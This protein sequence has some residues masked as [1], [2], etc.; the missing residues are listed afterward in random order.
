MLTID[1]LDTTKLS[2]RRRFSHL[3]YQFYKGVPQWVPPILIDV[4]TAMN[5]AKHPFYE[6]SDADFF[7]ANRDGQ[8]VGR[9]S[10]IE[11]KPYNQ[12]HGLKR[13]Q[14]YFFE[15]E[16][17]LDTAC[18]LFERGYEWARQRG[19]NEF[20]GPKGFGPLDGY[21][22]LIEGFEHRQMMTMMNYNLPYLPKMMETMGYE[23]EVDFISCYADAEH[24]ILPDRVRS[25]SNRVQKRGTLTVK[26]F[27]D[28]AE[29]KQWAP[30]IGKAYNSAFVN[31]WEY[32]PLTDREVK[33][34]VDQIITVA[35]HRL[36]KVILHGDDVVGFL[37]AFPDLSASLQRHGG[38]LL[39]F[40]ILDLI[41]EMKR[42]QW[43]S[44][45]GAGI[46][47]EFQGHG[48]NAVMYDVMEST[49]RD[50]GFVHGEMTQVAETAVNMRNDLINLGG[51]PYKNHRVFHKMI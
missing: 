3:P 7:I 51:K 23:K 29:L 49:I 43:V 50:F 2:Q 28:K 18:A 24:F 38:H 40:G 36:I 45:N 20:V 35:D 13:V 48:G 11:N 15:C 47:P 22:L 31:N 5:P 42:T 26:P 9:L 21:G 34:V 1:K 16:D 27:K 10:V 46:L 33:Y 37:F 14:F 6:H 39:P 12:Y 4:E 19:L 44:V 32:A 8:D 17:N 25:I 30:R 41:R